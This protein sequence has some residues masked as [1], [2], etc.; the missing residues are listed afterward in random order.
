MYEERRGMQKELF[1]FYQSNLKARGV[2]RT[3]P[4]AGWTCKNTPP[5]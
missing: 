4:I 1:M 2:T 5:T 3:N